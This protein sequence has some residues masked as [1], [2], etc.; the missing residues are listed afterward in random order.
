MRT[1]AACVPTGSLGYIPY[2]ATF[3][4]WPYKA[5]IVSIRGF[6][7]LLW[8]SRMEAH[9]QEY[10]C[11]DIHTRGLPSHW[12]QARISPPIPLSPVADTG[13]NGSTTMAAG[14]GLSHTFPKDPA[15][16]PHCY[17]V[18]QELLLW[19]W[20]EG[21]DNGASVWTCNSKSQHKLRCAVISMLSVLDRLF[22]KEPGPWIP[23][24]AAPLCQK[25]C[26]LPVCQPQLTPAHP[27]LSSCMKFLC[28]TR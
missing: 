6:I 14:A 2:T 7:L 21:W 1:L 24:W 16:L 3:H 22:W 9:L 5:V 20:A 11:W 15:C 23:W 13:H 17:K 4:R 19:W 10:I 8:L 28:L 18:T 27:A 25:R 12:A 26:H